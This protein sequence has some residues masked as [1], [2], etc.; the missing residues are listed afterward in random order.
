MEALVL[1]FVA[2]VGYL[3]IGAVF[4]PFAYWRTM[5]QMYRERRSEDKAR[6]IAKGNAAGVA[7]TWPVSVP[8]WG[9]CLLFQTAVEHGPKN[10]YQLDKAKQ[11][12]IVDPAYVMELERDVFD[13]R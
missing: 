12:R 9:Y 10:T 2:L 7:L 3:L 6:S 5:N 1:A 11:G 8:I 4:A 13:R